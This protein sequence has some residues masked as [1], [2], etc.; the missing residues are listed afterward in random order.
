M[1]WTTAAFVIA[2][3]TLAGLPPFS[4]YWSEKHILE[5][6]VTKQPGWAI[7]LLVLITLAGVYIGRAAMATFG[8][9]RKTEQSAKVQISW[10]MLAPLGALAA[11]AAAFGWLVEQPVASVLPW[12]TLTHSGRWWWTAGAIAASI[13]GLSLG[14]WRVRRRPVPA[15]GTWARAL[16]QTVHSVTAM[17][18]RTIRSA[19]MACGTLEGGFDQFAY[20]IAKTALAMAEG[21]RIGEDRIIWIGNDRLAYTL[22]QAG[23]RLGLLEGG[24]VSLYAASVF[25]WV[26]CASL[27]IALL[28][29]LISVS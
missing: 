27:M 19:S 18:S 12:P 6:A 23:A 11:A 26:L 8:L 10:I 24:K 21:T 14:A 13:T 9:W 1:P 5:A 29:C 2:A 20:S 16:G 28:T 3:L 25:V 17:V 15:F 4:G 7:V 22:N